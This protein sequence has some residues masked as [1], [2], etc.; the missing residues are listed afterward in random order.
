MLMMVPRHPRAISTLELQEKLS[1]QGYV[2]NLRS[3]QRDLEKLS[4]RFPL[5]SDEA[6]RPY[7]WS[8]SADAA[9]KLIPT[10]D[11]STAITLELARSYLKPIL[12][13]P[14]LEHL[15]PYF[16]EA[17]EVINKN[18]HPIA[19]WP[20]KIRLIHR[21]IGQAHIEIDSEIL[22]CLTEAVIN[23]TQCEIVYKARNWKQSEKVVIH[24]LGLVYRAP[25]TYVIATIDDREGVR[26]LALQRIEA[27]A[28]LDKEIC[29]PN[30]FNLDAYIAEGEMKVLLSKEKLELHLRCDKP[31]LNHVLESP[32][33]DDQ[34]IIVDTDQYFEVRCTMHD[35]QDL[36]WW[37]ISQ[38]AYLTVL[39]PES[40]RKE[41]MKTLQSAVQR[42]Q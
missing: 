31:M 21:A 22:E 3:I 25:N 4:L 29:T 40:L 32:L 12:P 17:H 10:L 26:Q 30:G 41:V 34:N 33:A 15:Q 36:R 16:H 18:G 20:E 35:S 14:I 9:L 8:F 38:S 27:A 42:H 23:E 39:A 6:V 13:K 24:P 5:V 7:R 2:I 28:R 19:H 37:L 1:Q 11:T